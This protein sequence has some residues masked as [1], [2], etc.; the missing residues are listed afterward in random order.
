MRTTARSFAGAVRQFAFAGLVLAL[1]AGAAQA[2]VENLSGQLLIAAPDLTDRNFSRTVV[3][4]LSHDESGALGL[5]V[6]EPMGEVPLQLLLKGLRSEEAEP[7]QGP[8]TP[9]E[10]ILVHYGGPVDPGRGF[11]LHSTD[12]MPPDSVRLGEDIAVSGKQELL[13]VL[14]G[15]DRPEHLMVFFGYSGWAPGQLEAE[16]ERGD[17]YISPWDKSLVFGPEA[18]RKWD[19]AVARYGP[20]L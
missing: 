6:N 19:R 13:E 1:A 14:V 4:M 9:G 10:K 18:A 12:V 3:Y 15:E 5:V 17:W 11:I 7:E 8:G 16:I 20:E 2:K